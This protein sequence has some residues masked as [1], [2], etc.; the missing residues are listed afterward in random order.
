MEIP[1]LV[2]LIQG[3]PE[4]ISIC[5]LVYVIVK[6]PFKLKEILF[7]GVLLATCAYI[8][9][10]LPITFGVH[11]VILIGILFSYLSII[12]KIE[13]S[14]AITSSLFVYLTLIILESLAVPSLMYLFN[15]SREQLL[16]TNSIRILIT[17]PHVF[18]III[19]SFFVQT[20]RLS[21]KGSGNVF[22]FK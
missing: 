7:M 20:K 19:I 16:S 2:F 13:L 6:I 18:V 8:I 15:I 17:L 3:I 12:K 11:T 1:F 21:K 10:L 4:Q 9:R 22:K 5:M 14:K